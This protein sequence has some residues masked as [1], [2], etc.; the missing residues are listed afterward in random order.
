MAKVVLTEGNIRKQIINFAW[1]IFISNIFNEFYNI[2]NS[3]IVG[4]YVSLKALS[5]VSACVWICNIFNY[6]FY[7]LG[8][9]TGILVGK[10]YGAKDRVNLK[11]VLDTALVFALLGGIAS[12]IL[13]EVFLTDLMRLCNISAD[14]YDL[15]AS[16]LRVYFL[17]HTAVLTYQVCFFVLRNFG[18]TKHQLYFSIVSSIVNITLG[19]IFVRVFNLSVVGTALA[20][21]ISQLTMDFL[22]LRL[23]FNYDEVTLDIKNIDF[24]F[25]V[26]REICSLGIPAS[27][28][29]L[30]IAISSMMI[31]SHVNTFSNEV[32]AGIGVAEKITNW[33]QMASLAIS[34]AAMALVA[35]NM[36]AKNYERVRIAIK[37]CIW[38]STVLTIVSVAVLY[39][40][41]PWLVRRFN[42]SELVVHYG[43]DMIRYSIFAMFFV[44]FSHI[45]NASCRAGGNVK[46]PMFIAVFC[47]CI[48]KYLFVHIGLLINHDVHVLYLG[49]AFGFTLAGIIATIYFYNS[50][51][52]LENGLR[53]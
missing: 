18:D 43:T 40:A 21:F 39:L 48:C 53:S 14:L 34:S 26:V 12:T 41:A 3:L 33:G 22:T 17:G 5:A 32:I 2:T 19:M 8:M 45:Y 28:Q 4:N 35:Q 44:N 31:Q 51:W 15:A 42:D 50:K 25:E 30:L 49:T 38:I 1:P 29:N 37:E 36:G 7:G 16:Y 10:Y 11:K 23:L 9:G 6:T 52:T 13:S 20:T 47:Q 27:I 46:Y 24:S